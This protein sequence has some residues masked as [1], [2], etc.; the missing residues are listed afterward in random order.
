M[1]HEQPEANKHDQDAARR[2]GKEPLPE[3]KD[4]THKDS[5]K[6]S[7]EGVT[8]MQRGAGHPTGR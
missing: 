8:G 6:G 3:H 1:T 5:Q 7:G 4:L 2:A